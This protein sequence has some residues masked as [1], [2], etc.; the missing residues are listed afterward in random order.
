MKEQETNEIFS[1]L[2]EYP[3]SES[4]R[5]LNY[6]EEKSLQYMITDHSKLE[7]IFIKYFKELRL[8]LEEWLGPDNFL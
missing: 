3:Q 8:L 5:C 6:E 1:E 4:I 2:S 7:V